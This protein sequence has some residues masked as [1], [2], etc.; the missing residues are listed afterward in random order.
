MNELEV[1]TV[2]VWQLFLALD[3]DMIRCGREL[4]SQD[5]IERAD[6]FHF[7]RDRQR[8][9]A[10]RFGMRMI[11]SSYLGLE[12]KAVAFSYAANG[13]PALAASLGR[14]DI[15]FNLSHSHEYALLAVARTTRLGADIEFI[16]QDVAMD[17]IASSFFSPDEC[18]TVASLP[19]ENRLHAFYTC[20]TRKEAYLKA[21][22][23]GL[24]L[25][26]N[27]FDV[28]C[29]P[30]IPPA[31]LRVDGCLEEPSRWRVYDLETPRQYVAALVIEGE[32]HRLIRREWKPEYVSRNRWQ[33]RLPHLVP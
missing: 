14:S 32:H 7:E 31:L 3:P 6:R 5:E 12:P 26:M 23:V 8:F 13:K 2:H 4:L 33:Q 1:N 18:R 9:T 22:G 11:L 25:A 27:S 30:S 16:K 20:W 24:S 19:A 21:K 17:E 15:Q 28:A 10:A 29:A